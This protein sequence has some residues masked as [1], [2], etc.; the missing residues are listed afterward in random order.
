MQLRDR[1][2]V[3]QQVFS[4]IPVYTGDVS[5]AASALYELGG[6][7]AIHDPSG[8]NSTYNTHDEIRWYDEESLIF[9]SGLKES[10]ALLGR[11]DVFIQ[12]IISAAKRL[13]PE[14]IA[15]RP[16]LTSAERTF[17]LFP[18]LWK[19]KQGCL[20]FMS[21]QMQCTIIRMAREWHF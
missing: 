7:L 13:S 15:I 3:R 18:G 14:F 6:L 20:H 21:V 11:D 1:M 8:C 2:K 10:D 16:F 19:K 17:M 5:G 12:D 4:H 9:I